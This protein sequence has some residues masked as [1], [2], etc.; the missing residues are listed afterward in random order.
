VNHLQRAGYVLRYADNGEERDHLAHLE[1]SKAK[2]LA[3]ENLTA[4]DEG[5]LRLAK[6]EERY[7]LFLVLGN[8]PFEL[9]ADYTYRSDIPDAMDSILSAWSD[10]WENRK[11]PTVTK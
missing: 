3:V 1:P 7:T 11:C 5:W 2:K 4:C 9:V 6:G 10:K 8:E